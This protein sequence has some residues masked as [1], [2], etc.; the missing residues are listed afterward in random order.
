MLQLPLMMALKDGSIKRVRDL[1]DRLAAEFKLTN[2]E[3]AER[4]P[5]GET[6]FEKRVWFALLNLKNAGLAE[7]N[8]RGTVQIAAAGVNVVSN[9]PQIID[10]AFLMRFDSYRA[11]NVVSRVPAE[12]GIENARLNPTPLV[13]LVDSDPTPDD[14][15]EAA[16]RAHRKIME[17]QLLEQVRV[18]GHRFFE[19]VVVDVLVAMGYGG[20]RLNAGVAFQTT[21]DGGVDGVIN[22]DALGL[23]RVYI[24]AKCNAE[25]NSVGR[26]PLQGFVGA[27]HT[28]RAT[29]G[30]FV[31]TSSFTSHAREYA[32]DHGNIA[33]IDGAK[34][35]ALM[36]DFNVGAS[37]AGI[38][39][40]KK[41]DHD[42]FDGS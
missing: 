40:L 18:A 41:I 27:L 7:S 3:R 42:Y 31:T 39:Q 23:D 14:Q 2:H 1:I 10:R 8:A 13:E 36:L 34:L 12:R 11:K 4:F 30:V 25:N 19:K 33:L 29:K 28:K 16:Y 35:V 17:G 38:Y 26:P 20:G 22:E 24:Q 21:G 15:M 37:P 32:E 6:K 5:S 9:P